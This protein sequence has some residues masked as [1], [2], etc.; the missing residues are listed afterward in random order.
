MKNNLSHSSKD[1]TLDFLKSPY[2]FISKICR[3]KKTNIV[4][5][6]LMLKKTICIKGRD[7]AKIFYDPD[8]F[9]RNGANPEPVRSTLFGKG[10]IQGFDGKEHRHRKEMFMS[11]MS[12]ESIESFG[13]IVRDWLNI[14]AINWNQKGSINL[15]LEL[16]KVLTQA[17]CEWVGIPLKTE[18]VEKRSSDIS[19]LFNNV[20][21]SPVDN[22]RARL[23]RRRSEKWIEDIIQNVRRSHFQF[24][25]DSPALLICWHRTLEDKLLTPH[26]AAVEILNLIRPTVAVSLYGVFIA[27]ALH[28]HQ[29]AKQK[30][31]RGED[32]YIDYFIQEVRRFYPFFPSVMAKVKRDFDWKGVS[33]R[34]GTRVI[35]DIYGTNH[36]PQQWDHPYSFWPERF[37]NWDGDAFN[38]IPQG[39]GDYLNGHRCPGEWATIEIMKQ[40]VQFLVKDINYFVPEQNMQLNMKQIPASIDTGM[41][42]TDV[43]IQS[44]P[45][46]LPDQMRGD[47]DNFD[48]FVHP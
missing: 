11:I 13:F 9:I 17:S 40:I 43:M 22:L 24:H 18:D 3:E 39:G 35:L 1:Q 41:I 7:A 6:R 4:E 45:A 47:S 19:Y 12:P 10:G 37:K 14:S 23:A 33:F 46:T 25:P 26:E 27:H 2:T 38:F 31:L 44:N 36:D 20:G 16:Q 30:I 8:L 5:T 21:P 29:E 15:Y 32:K 34:Q 48:Q 42:L 28:I